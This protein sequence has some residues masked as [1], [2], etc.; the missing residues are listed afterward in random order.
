MKGPVVSRLE[1]P[2]WE[3]VSETAR[4]RERSA[5]VLRSITL[6][7]TGKHCCLV[8]RSHRC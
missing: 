4:E 7:L 2:G 5:K 8:V 1:E 3:A 6:L